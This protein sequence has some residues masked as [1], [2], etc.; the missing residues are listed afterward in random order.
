MGF[1]VDQLT[2]R[3]SGTVRRHALPTQADNACVSIPVAEF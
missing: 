3:G 2:E 1:P